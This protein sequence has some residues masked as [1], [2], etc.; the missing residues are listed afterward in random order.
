[1]SIAARLARVEAR[2]AS[3]GARVN[4]LALAI[5]GACAAQGVPVWRGAVPS[6][7]TDAAWAAHTAEWERAATAQ[8]A[9]LM[10]RPSTTPAPDA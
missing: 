8:Q 1:M 5:A 3:A 9:E 2:L 10:A 7:H 6:G 4:P